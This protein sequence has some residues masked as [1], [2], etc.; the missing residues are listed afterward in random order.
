MKRAI[1]L[2]EDNSD[3]IT[4]LSTGCDPLDSFIGIC[5]SHGKGFLYEGIDGYIRVMCMNNTFTNPVEVDRGFGSIQGVLENLGVPKTSKSIA[6]S[7][8]NCAELLEWL[9]EKD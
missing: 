4:Y 2:V 1:K 5:T 6:F 8:D 3:C 7:F 9:L